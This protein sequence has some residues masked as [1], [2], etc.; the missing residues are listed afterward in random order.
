M[1]TPTENYDSLGKRPT[2][3]DSVAGVVSLGLVGLAVGI[4]GPAV[5]MVASKSSG[6]W[7]V[8]YIITLVICGLLAAILGI[9]AIR[10]SGKLVEYKVLARVLG[11][12]STVVGSIIVGVVGSFLLLMLMFSASRW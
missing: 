6:W 10:K 5:V 9:A 11:V 3:S 8:P 4:S 1:T 2:P 7:S 12:I